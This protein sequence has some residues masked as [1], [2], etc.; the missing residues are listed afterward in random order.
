M[1]N[2]W[3]YDIKKRDERKEKMLKDMHLRN[4]VGAA[5]GIQQKAKHPSASQ[6]CHLIPYNIHNSSFSVRGGDMIDASTITNAG[7]AV[8][9]SS[10]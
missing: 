3:L 7:G 9:V 5:G 2:M 4:G 10:R 8:Q 6:A 1:K